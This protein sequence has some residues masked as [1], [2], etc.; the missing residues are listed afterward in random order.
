MQIKEFTV[1]PAPSEASTMAQDS[2]ACEL[3][4]QLG[5]KGQKK[6]ITPE[7]ETRCRYAKMTKL[8][9]TVYGTLFPQHTEITEYESQSIPLRVLQILALCM[10]E[11]QFD[12]YVVWHQA[13]PKKD[14][15]LVGIKK[16]GQW[17]EDVY[18][19][20]QW[21]DALA[22]FEA[23]TAKAELVIEAKVRA[24]LLKVQQSVAAALATV[25]QDV[26]AELL[27]EGGKLSYSFYA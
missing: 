13:D 22:P 25:K 2:E 11:K 3:I 27:S 23:L 14:P 6:L 16:T 12:K 7:T 10:Q 26:H 8:E 18:L 24:G 19:I 5:L 9:V 4:E 20:A 21:G 1:E 17:S 15:L